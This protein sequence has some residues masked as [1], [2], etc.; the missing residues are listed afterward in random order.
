M[1]RTIER[2]VDKLE[3][4]SRRRELRKKNANRFASLLSISLRM[5]VGICLFVSGVGLILFEVFGQLSGS[6]GGGGGGFTIVGWLG[7][8]LFVVGGT[9]CSLAKLD[10]LARKKNAPDAP[11]IMLAANLK[12]KEDSSLKRNGD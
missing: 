11:S 7:L 9:L 1:R 3:V 6:G 8:A 12:Q 4:S 2:F 5:V 10:Y